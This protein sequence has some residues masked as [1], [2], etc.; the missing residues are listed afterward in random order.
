VTSER[1]DGTQ[2]T[3]ST[4]RPNV[5]WCVQPDSDEPP[6]HPVLPRGVSLLTTP[7]C[8]VALPSSPPRAATWP[9]PPH[10]PV[11][12]RGRCVE[13]DSEPP[14]N[15]ARIAPSIGPWE[16]E[17]LDA[18]TFADIDIVFRKEMGSFWYR[19]RVLTSAEGELSAVSR[20]TLDSCVARSTPVDLWVALSLS[21][22]CP[23][24]R[25]SPRASDGSLRRRRRPTDRANAA[26]PIE[27]THYAFAYPPSNIDSTELLRGL[28]NKKLIELIDVGGA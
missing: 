27:A 26:I 17:A 12:P 7:C 11:L 14:T 16:L 2:A 22:G 18:K 10:H 4:M 19:H 25:C 21:A 23:L 5:S 28:V 20:I 24:A 8:H 9:F 6:H 3:I 13:P 1:C 15:L